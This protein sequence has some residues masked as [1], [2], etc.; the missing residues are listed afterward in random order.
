ME[1]THWSQT[2]LDP[3]WAESYV[4]PAGG[5]DL[6]YGNLAMGW[7]RWARDPS[8]AFKGNVGHLEIKSRHLKKGLSTVDVDWQC[9][10]RTKD[11]PAMDGEQVQKARM[12]AAK[13][14]LRTPAKWKMSAYATTKAGTVLDYTRMEE[15]ATVQPGRIA[16]GTSGCLAPRAVACSSS[17]TTNWSLLAA[18]PWMR[19]KYKVK[20]LRFDLLED[21]CFLRRGLRLTAEDWHDFQFGQTTVPLYGYKM[22][23]TGI[24]PTW[25]WLDEGHR[26]LLVITSPLYSFYLTHLRQEVA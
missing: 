14:C 2:W 4:P 7:S 17:L 21:L 25:F 15:S 12:V 3:R 9:S 16:F 8:K 11:H 22:M 18:L 6:K 23:G 24:Q 10:Q 5:I 13:D 26:P 1:K 20:E 19:P